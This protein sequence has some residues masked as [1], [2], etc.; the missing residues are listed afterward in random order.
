MSTT[1]LI[2]LIV[3]GISLLLVGA[4]RRPAVAWQPIVIRVRRRHF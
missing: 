1:I 4:H 2:A 3:L